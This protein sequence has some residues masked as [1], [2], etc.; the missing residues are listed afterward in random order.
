MKKIGFFLHPTMEWVGGINYYRNLFSAI[1]K[2]DEKNISAIVFLPK[3]LDKKIVE[4][5]ALDE[6]NL[7]VVRTTM[8][9]K[10]SPYW[11][12]WK[13]I[14]KIFGSDLAAL[15]LCMMYGIRI[16]SH[17][18]FANIPIVRIINW[19]PDFQHIHLSAFFGIKEAR[20][21]DDE[22][23]RLIFGA[24]RVVV[25]SNIAAQD[26]ERLYPDSR[27]KLFI[28]RFA[29]SAPDF[30]WKLDKVSQNSLAKRYR[31]EEHF[32]YIP[33]QFWVHKNHKILIDA[34]RILKER[35]IKIQMVLSG[36]TQDYRNPNYFLELK[37][38]IIDSDCEDSFRVLNIIS[39]RDVYSLIKFSL[40][41]INPSRFEGWSSS[42]EEC[43]SVGKKMIL[44][45]I[46]VHH[47]QLENALFFKVDNASELA[48]RIQEIWNNRFSEVNNNHLEII[49]RNKQKILEYGERYFELIALVLA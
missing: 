36:A 39:Y 28:L 27:S 10:Y 5:L 11:F 44:S 3:N 19:I 7:K 20:K 33:N 6:R 8:L 29:I 46:P 17:S 49:E 1:N 41:V 16:V 42:V 25:S 4:M 43:K 9:Q 18:N 14:R 23:S 47:E 38:Y 40:A 31:I 37:K 15:P 12:F 45:D 24:D 21:R 32:F 30:Y 26:L 2:I 13:F 35:D 22:F 34:T 48:D